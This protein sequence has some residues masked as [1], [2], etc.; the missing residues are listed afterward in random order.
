[1]NTICPIC[2]QKMRKNNLVIFKCKHQMHLKCYLESLK[3]A[4][5]KCPLC[6]DSLNEN[7]KYF[8]FLNKKF[9]KVVDSLTIEKILNSFDK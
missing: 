4:T 7:K 5:I 2:L 3:H 1:M 6:K 8:K 9:E